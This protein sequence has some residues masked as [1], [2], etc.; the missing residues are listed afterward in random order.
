MAPG[1]QQTA[2]GDAEPSQAKNTF[3]S[4][5]HHSEVRLPAFWRSCMC[6]TFAQVAYDMYSGRYKRPQYQGN[7]PTY[8]G[9]KIFAR[10]LSNSVYTLF[11]L[12]R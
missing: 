4:I 2:A 8:M 7:G 10:I 5:P 9:S 6:G 1:T 12:L 11:G 3:K